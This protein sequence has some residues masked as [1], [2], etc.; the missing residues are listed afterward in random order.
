M[1]IKVLIFLILAPICML[2]MGQVQVASQEGAPQQTMMGPM[3]EYSNLTALGI[4]AIV[5]IYI[6]SKMLPNLHDKIANQ[7]TIFVEAI[8]AIM[9]KTE[10]REQVRDARMSVMSDKMMDTML[11]VA[12]SMGSLQTHCMTQLHNMEKLSRET[13]QSDKET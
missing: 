5:L 8:R 13:K 1:K 11:K 2:A 6:V 3:T 4:L 7:T 9:E 12:E 10:T